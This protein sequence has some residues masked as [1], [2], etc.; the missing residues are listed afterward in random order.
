[1]N[2]VALAHFTGQTETVLARATQACEIAERIG[3]T[4]SRVK[5]TSVE[6]HAPHFSGQTI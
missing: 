3:S 4:Q 1:M 6:R 5:L 2:A